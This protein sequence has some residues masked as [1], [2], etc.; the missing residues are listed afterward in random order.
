MAT[1]KRAARPVKQASTRP[2]LKRREM[3]EQIKPLDYGLTRFLRMI[4][5][6][7]P[8]VGKTPLAATAKNA[9]ILECDRGVESAVLAGSTAKKWI[10]SDYHDLTAAYE[11]LRNGGYHDFETLILDSGSMMMQRGMDNIMADL[12]AR[13][14]NRFGADWLPDKGEYF[15]NQQRFGKFIRDFVD[16]DI[17]LIVTAWAFVEEREMANGDIESRM[18][19]GLPGRNYS[20]KICGYMGIVAH[21]QTVASKKRDGEYPVLSTQRRDKWYA[22]D[23]YAIIGRMP[24]PTIPKIMD[25]YTQKRNQLT[26][27]S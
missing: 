24:H 5:Y 11:Y 19:P 16:L 27:E 1:T 9:L 7:F 3:P 13:K 17:N 2:K 14:P 25:A 21:L 12:A 15:Q 23:R 10:I 8:G 26:K 6:G 18:M 4:I 20:D 22:K